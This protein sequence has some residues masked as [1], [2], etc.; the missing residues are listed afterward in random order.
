MCHVIL[1]F[2][3]FPDFL[4]ILLEPFKSSWSIAVKWRYFSK[5]LDLIHVSLE[6]NSQYR[7]W[8]ETQAEINGEREG[9]G[10][11]G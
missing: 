2:R 5:V 6:Q 9:L 7:F 4:S 1:Y 8:I 3:F 11:E 10:R